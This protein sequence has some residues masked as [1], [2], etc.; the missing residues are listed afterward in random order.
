L[1]RQNLSDHEL[2][3]IVETNFQ[4][5]LPKEK[6]NYEDLVANFHWIIMRTRRI[7]KITKEQFAEDIRE[8]IIAI[9]SLERGVLPKDYSSLIRK[10][11]NYLNIPIFK[12]SLSKF[13]K[14]SVLQENHVPSGM[15]IAD[16]KKITDKEKFEIEMNSKSIN[17]EEISINKI[18]EVIGKPVEDQN[19]QKRK[20]F[21]SRLFGGGKISASKPL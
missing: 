3:K 6:I 16:L 2:K 11:E 21:F 7:K 12:D 8:P 9:E 17:P 18:E 5:N 15:T 14:S 20:N 4:K 13:D 1:H 10:I 19:A